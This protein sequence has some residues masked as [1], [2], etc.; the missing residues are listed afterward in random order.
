M[1]VWTEDDFKLS[2]DTLR[3]VRIAERLDS[4]LQ[5]HL[6]YGDRER[7]V[8]VDIL[9]F[10]DARRS[11]NAYN[12]K[13]GNGSYDGGK[14]RLI[15]EELVRTQILLTDYGRSIGLSSETSNAHVIFY[16]G[17]L[18]LPPPLAI[19]GDDLD[20]HFQFPVHE[21]IELVNAYFVT[22]LSALIEQED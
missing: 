18:S 19:S 2:H 15:H 11:L 1:R 4:L 13:R 8:R 10:D 6:P 21:A 7:S 12:I 22:R 17:L 14:R 16:Y 3:E 9:V 5:V 20:E